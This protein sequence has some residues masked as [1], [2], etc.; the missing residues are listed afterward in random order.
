MV[1]LAAA[2]VEDRAHALP[3]TQLGEIRI[4]EKDRESGVALENGVAIDDHGNGLIG[5]SRWKGQHAR[6]R[7][8]ITPGESSAILGPEGDGHR[9][10]GQS[11]EAH[12]EN[13]VGGRSRKALC[14]RDIVDE[15]AWK[16]VIIENS[17]PPLRDAERS[18]ARSRE[19]HEESF[20]R[21]VH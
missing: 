11:S 21:F 1:E 2:V 12:V 6:L 17:A 10:A 18:I 19:V 5:C 15:E 7:H 9:E 14:H 8:V 20:Y 16:K 13:R 3:I 4:T